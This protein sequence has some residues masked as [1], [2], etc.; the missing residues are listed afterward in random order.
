MR[1]IA[2]AG[3]SSCTVKTAEAPLERI[4]LLLQNQNLVDG[5]RPYRSFMDAARRIPQEQGVLSLWR[6]NFTNCCRVF[7]TYALRFAFMDYYQRLA[8][9]GSDAQSSGELSLP[10]Q[11]L[12][13]ALA[14]G[15]AMLVVYPLDLARTRLSVHVGQSAGSGMMRLIGETWRAQGRRGI[16]R[17]MGISLLEIMPYTAVAMGGYEFLKG[18]IPA[19]GAGGGA[20]ELKKLGAGWVSGVSASLICYPLDTVKRQLMIQNGAGG[21]G[22]VIRSLYASGGVRGFYHG[23]TL[24]ALK[25]APCVALT[26]V[27]ND[28][29]REAVGFE[30][31]F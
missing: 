2:A 7:P 31:A 9:F 27:L 14:G 12:S 22:A 8:S 30:K 13:G 28:V 15:S 25:S 17:G 1:T 3:G 20:T 19:D 10:R 6:G 4:K 23:C 18:Q 5:T 24:N 29:I 16:Y 26:Y 21:A 11:M